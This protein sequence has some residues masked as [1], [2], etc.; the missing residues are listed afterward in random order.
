M[1]TQPQL[2]LLRKMSIKPLTCIDLAPEVKSKRVDIRE[3]P[4]VRVAQTLTKL[5]YARDYGDQHGRR[6]EVRLRIWGITD[7]GK[8]VLQQQSLGESTSKAGQSQLGFSL[9]PKQVMNFN[10][11]EAKSKVL[12]IKTCVGDTPTGP[13]TKKREPTIQLLPPEPQSTTKAPKEN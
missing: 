13:A 10:L 11:K 2:D 1:M 9:E 4:T 6:T 12:T 7:S 3:A 8:A 5:G